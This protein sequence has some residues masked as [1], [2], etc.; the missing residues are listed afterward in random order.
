[1]AVGFTNTE[2]PLPLTACVTSFMYDPKG[3][4]TINVLTYCIVEHSHECFKVQVPD[5]PL[6]LL[7][8]STAIRTALSFGVDATTAALSDIV[9]FSPR[10]FVDGVQ[11]VQAV[12]DHLHLSVAG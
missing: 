11:I 4:F 6:P 5:G 12:R 1:M 8:V 10:R 7:F 3:Y 9:N 2:N